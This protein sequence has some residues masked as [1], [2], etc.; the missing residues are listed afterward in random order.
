MRDHL[1]TPDV[2][3]NGAPV[4]EWCDSVGISDD[5]EVGCPAAQ[6]SG[7]QRRQTIPTVCRSALDESSSSSSSSCQGRRGL[8]QTDDVFD[9]PSTSV[10]T[11]TAKRPARSPLSSSDETAHTQCGTCLVSRRRAASPPSEH[12]STQLITSGTERRPFVCPH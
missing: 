1:H 10:S 2:R 6:H 11:T 8:L 12:G 5:D 4:L 9:N 3:W 7:P